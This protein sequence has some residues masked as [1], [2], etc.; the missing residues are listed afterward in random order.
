MSSAANPFAAFG[1]PPVSFLRTIED[2]NMSRPYMLWKYWGIPTIVIGF[3][4]SVA[5]LSVDGALLIATAFGA[6]VGSIWY[7]A[8]LAMATLRNSVVR[9]TAPPARPWAV[10]VP[11]VLLITYVMAYGAL[12]KRHTSEN[13]EYGHLMVRH[14]VQ[15]PPMP[16]IKPTAIVAFFGPVH[17]LD[18]L[19]RFMYWG[20]YCISLP[21]VVDT[22]DAI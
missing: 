22:R 14:S 8:A 15:Y 4:L 16:F 3:G 10:I 9:K 13:E 2:R 11:A 7:M 6:I 20:D 19:L 5:G 18:E 21:P 1:A 12:A 17:R